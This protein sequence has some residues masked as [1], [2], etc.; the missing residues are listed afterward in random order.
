MT[1]EFFPLR[2]EFIA[3]DSIY[4]APGMAANTLRG[5]L[6]TIFRKLDCG[7]SGLYARIFEP[8]SQATGP[9]GLADSPRPFVF[10]ARHLDG[11]TVQPGQPFHFDMHVFTPEKEILSHFTRAFA[12]FACEGL[13][14]KRGKAEL[15]RVPEPTPI[16][17]DLSPAFPASG[18]IRI[19]FLSPTEL[20]HEDHIAHQP[21]FPILFARVRDRISTLRALYGPGPLDIDFHGS[22]LRAAAVKMMRCEV[23][24]VD[25]QRRSSRT[26][27][28][29]PLGGFIGAA[30]YEGDLAEF[31]PYL[32][33]A[34]WA[35]V[36]RQAV[37]GKGEIGITLL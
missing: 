17:L 23:H 7:P 19:D 22:G 2:F 13:G 15:Q 4:F 3:R 21:D 12:E 16:S 10:R 26:G 30:E 20:K 11:K 36:G 34:R 8:T 24:R 1:F 5:A 18:K 6:G 28:T 32:E 35:G 27:Q 9:S 33:A 14:P 31:L 25:A 37:W 29:H